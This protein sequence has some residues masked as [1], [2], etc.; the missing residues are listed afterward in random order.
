M[1]NEEV[2][3]L[4]QNPTDLEVHEIMKSSTHITTKSGAQICE[5]LFPFSGKEAPKPVD[6]LGQAVLSLDTTETL[7]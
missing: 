3:I 1:M 2:A 6:P 5:V 4:H 7:N